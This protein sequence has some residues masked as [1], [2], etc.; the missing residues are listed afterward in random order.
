M[1][2]STIPALTFGDKACGR[3]LSDGDIVAIDHLGKD[4]G[5]LDKEMVAF[6]V[7]GGVTIKWLKFFADQEL[8]VGVP[9]NKDEFDTVVTLK[10]EEI[11]EGIVGRVAWWWA[12]RS[13]SNKK[14]GVEWR[15][16][17]ARA[18]R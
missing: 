11:D 4:P 6:R 14:A 16:E 8:V 1:T 15:K 12:K 13:P 5:Q 7:G 18:F 9:E 17:A 10:G 2:R 3:F